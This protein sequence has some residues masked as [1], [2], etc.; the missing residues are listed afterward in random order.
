M[1]LG[2]AHICTRVCLWLSPPYSPKNVWVWQLPL[3]RCIGCCVV[4]LEYY[5]FPI[6]KNLPQQFNNCWL[7]SAEAYLNKGNNTIIEHRAIFQRERQNSYVNKQTKSVNNQKTGKTAMALTWYRHVQRNGGLN[8]I[9]RRQT[10]RFHY[11]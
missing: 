2:Y 1:G 3:T 7:L 4:F 9:L 11:G 6:K 8:Q 5:G 10:S